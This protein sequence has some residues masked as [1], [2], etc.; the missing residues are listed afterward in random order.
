M[1][2]IA[3]KSLYTVSAPQWFP[4]YMHHLYIALIA[5]YNEW[6]AIAIGL[7]AQFWHREYLVSYTLRSIKNFAIT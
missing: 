3:Y 1:F 6:L 2:C 5:I 7:H 4:H